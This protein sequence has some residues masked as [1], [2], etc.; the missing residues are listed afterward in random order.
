[1]TYSRLPP[2]ECLRAH[3]LVRQEAFVELSHRQF[4]AY[5]RAMTARGLGWNVPTAL[6]DTVTVVR[7]HIEHHNTGDDP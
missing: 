3:D 6:S 4:I 2:V 1:M 5:L 7:V